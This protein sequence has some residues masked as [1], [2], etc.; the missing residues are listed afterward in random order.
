MQHIILACLYGALLSA[1]VLSGCGGL[2]FGQ[3]CLVKNGKPC[4]DIVIAENPPRAVKLAAIELQSHLEKISGA[5]LAVATAPGT[6]VPNHIY[7]G[8]SPYTDKLD[9]TAEGLKYGAFKMVSG[10][11]YLVLLGHDSDFTPPLF[12]PAG[13]HDWARVM[14][15][16]DAR[17]GEKWGLPVGPVFK[18]YSPAVGVWDYDERGSLYAVY[19][20]LRSLG[21]RWYMPGDLGEVL[22]K[23]KSIALPVLDKTVKPDFPYRNLGNYSPPWYGGTRDAIMYRLRIGLDPIM[24]IPGPHG[25]ND[26]NG[27]EEVKKAHP[28]FYCDKKTPD[29]NDHYF[30]S[31]FSSPEL[32]A[33]T[34][35]FA[36]KVFEIYPE[37]QFIS[38]WPNDGFRMCHCDLCK[39]KE[40][41][42]RGPRGIASDY[43]WGFVD[44][45]ARELYKTHP[46]K[47]VI[48]GAYGAYTLPPTNIAKF[49]PNV[50]VGIV[51]SRVRFNDPNVYTQ[52]MSTRSGYLEKITPGNLHTYNHYLYSTY[53]QG[54]LPIYF[55]HFIAA[56]LRALKGHSQ[57]EFIEL[58]QGRGAGDMAAP[59]FNHL[60][61]YVT[62][63]Y[64]WDAG[65]DVDKMLDEY[66]RLY[67]GP[68]AKKMKAFVE[69]SE[70]NWPS[71]QT[72][73]EPIDR[74]LSLLEEA[75]RAAGDT[76]YGKRIDLVKNYVRPLDDI[77]LRLSMDRKD[78]PRA[79]H[80]WPATDKEIT[81]DGRLDEK[82]WNEGPRAW[83]T[84]AY[85]MSE[86]ETGR[87]AFCGTSWRIIWGGQAVY[88]GI[89][90]NERD[91]KAMNIATT[92]ND[93][94]AIFKGDYVQLLLET[95][96][97]SYYQIAVNPAGAVYDA[98]LK[99]G[100]NLAWSSS[101]KVAVYKGDDF[102]SVEMRVPVGDA[103]E[104][105]V[106]PAKCVEGR[107]PN[108]IYPWFINV[109]RQRVGKSEI[110]RSAW[111]PT[112]ESSFLVPLKFGELSDKW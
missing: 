54:G 32:E 56:D 39:G 19:E 86:T 30:G 105:G 97:H 72:K 26:V 69:Y 27:R 108:T 67:Y 68:A 50:M 22:P 65:Q 90:C 55:P 33:Y 43:V 96:G 92:N 110:E 34:V 76:V 75:R 24:D 9:I 64:Y 20:F 15:E 79:R 52:A 77:R 63:R 66:Y 87:R 81:I 40:A 53:G 35:K 46:D 82:N 98:D 47:K 3:P 12:S 6:N 48:C 62:A 103:I 83:N 25:L 109:C 16:W 45:V 44:R 80:I 59:E 60:N 107:C 31:C 73:L 106:D 28:E 74:A 49:S 17:T 71:M 36:R 58:S 91:M 1:C 10:G 101:A 8:R 89:H 51:D 23:C 93:D 94:A 21:A 14:K 5:R 18:S 99:G 85:G 38:I 111:S 41:P 57:G 102:W 78:V 42:E 13:H 29:P 95:Q 104:G 88:F 84:Y 37:R 112:G 11:D 100:T 2:N 61:V 4:A 7:I 70:T